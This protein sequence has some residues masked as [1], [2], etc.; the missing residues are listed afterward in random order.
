MLEV[1]AATSQS[2]VDLMFWVTAISAVLGLFVAI[3]KI[4]GPPFKAMKS[5]I[6]WLQ[7]FRDSWEGREATP[8]RSS[9]PGVLERLNRIDGE[10]SHNSGSSIKDAVVAI[11]QSIIGLQEQVDRME[12]RQIEVASLSESNFHTGRDAIERGNYNTKLIWDAMMKHGIDVP[13][14]LVYREVD[15]GANK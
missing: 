5:T 2:V 6:D 1:L 15:R 12:L 4:V 10:L 3:I 9:E 14:P 7:E 8:G 13:D 11:N